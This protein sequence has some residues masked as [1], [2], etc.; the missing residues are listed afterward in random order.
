[1]TSHLRVGRRRSISR[2]S[3]L[4]HGVAAGT[5][6]AAPAV[7]TTSRRAAA[8]QEIVFWQYKDP[9]GSDGFKYFEA[10][11]ERFKEQTGT[12]VQVRFKSAEGIEQAVAAAA[13]ARK[14]FDSL[15]WWSGP[16][17]R[18]QASLGNIMPLDDKI[19]DSVWQHKQGLESMRYEGRQ[20]AMP[21]DVSPWFLVYNRTLLAKA[22][23]AGDALPPPTED[24]VDWASFLDICGR[25]RKN[26]G[27]APLMW[28]NKEGY[29]NEWYFYNFQGQSFDSTAEIE[30]INLGDES[31]QHPDVHAALKAFQELYQAGYFVEGGEVVPYEQ[32]VRQFASGQC[33]MSVYFDL[34]GATTEAIKTFGQE[35]IAF[36]KIPAYRTDKKLHGHISQEP[37]SLY[38]ASFSDKQDA[39]VKW[40]THLASVP[41]MN[42]LARTTQQGPADNRWD[43]NLIENP[44]VREVFTGSA[45]KNQVYPY[46]FATQAQY[47]SLLRNGILYLSGEWTAEELTADWDKVDA[48]YKQ[49]QK[50][51]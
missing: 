51:G 49:Q 2:R 31:W 9:P 7:L 23:V 10:S 40:V 46:D 15:L 35:N 34:T 28:A 32:H 36:T 48:E 19:P 1:M 47:E 45:A 4:G 44:A 39:A 5:L 14:G 38:V 25:I 37:N 13:N 18:N 16:T 42:E 33:A 50:E 27:V 24:P 30:A 17:S 41:E 21:F 3:F 12:S 26:A 11:A 43:V 22:G 8:D 29:F 6:L 20:Y